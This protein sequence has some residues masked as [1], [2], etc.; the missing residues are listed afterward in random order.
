MKNK[1]N[2]LLLSTAIGGILFNAI[3]WEERLAL[4]LLIYSAFIITIMMLNKDIIKSTKFKI[5]AGAHLFASI[6]VV[7][8][9]SDLSIVAYHISLL[10]F[11]AYSHYQQIRTIFTALIAAMVQLITAPIGFLKNL[12]GVQIGNLNTK[13]FFKLLKYIVLPIFILFIFTCLYCAANEVFEKAV[14]A[15]LTNIGNFFYSIILF[16]FKDFDM[17]RV[18]FF[19]FGLL[20]TAGLLITFFSNF[21]EKIEST[22]KEQLLRVRKSATNSSVW[23]EFAQMLTGDLLKRKLALKTEYIIALISFASL[24]LLLLSLNVIDITTVWFNY[25]PAGNFSADLHQGANALIFSIILAMAVIICFFRGNLNF[26]HKSNTLRVMAYVWMVQN[27]ILIIS[28]FIRDGYYIE[29]HGLTHKRIGVIVF[30]ILCII[31][32]VTVYIKVAKQK[33]FF[34][35]LKVNGNIWFA[36][37]L[38]FTTINWDVFIVRYNLNHNNSITLD[39]DYL[40]SLSEKTLPLLD[41]NRAA[42]Y[43]NAN[44]ES[45]T[46]R[47]IYARPEKVLINKL[48]QRIGF[49]KDRYAEGSWLSWNLQ[50]WKTAKYFGL[51]K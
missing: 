40:L 32:L 22:F 35:L 49:F 21:L 25:T 5:Y 37:L 9:N 7:V 30:A 10:A 2:F 50:D 44:N 17:G 31:G 3:F 46:R 33:T 36:L 27:F 43:S 11:I 51:E 23:S 45:E 16:F 48:D 41:K 6:L 13:P 1:S 4:N 28:V 42:I 14:T 47:A 34:Y 24:N 38:A 8:N 39:P 15:L 26:Y 18:V 20:V 12:G 29:F 19:C